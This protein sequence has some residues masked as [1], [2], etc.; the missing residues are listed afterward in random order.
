M[1]VVKANDNTFINVVIVD[2]EVM[3]EPMRQHSVTSE[4]VIQI[5][6]KVTA[7]LYNR[8]LV[9][10]SDLLSHNI[11]KGQSYDV[12]NKVQHVRSVHKPRVISIWIIKNAI[13]H[14]N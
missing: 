6:C 9:Y 4:I 1:W 13:T 5:Q 7:D 14:G 12:L 10:S 8:A 11:K 3:T 2:S